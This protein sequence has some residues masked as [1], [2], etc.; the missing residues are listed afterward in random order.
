MDH[1]GLR[2]SGDA[3]ASAT[4]NKWTV[5]L[6][7]LQIIINNK[8]KCS[9]HTSNSL[10]PNFIPGLCTLFISDTLVSAIVHWA[11]PLYSTYRVYTKEKN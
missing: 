7:L 1:I 9:M 2:G 4:W 10:L 3:V 6:L 11:G 5:V 8:Q